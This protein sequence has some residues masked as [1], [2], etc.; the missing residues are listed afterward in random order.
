MLSDYTI[1]II[2]VII[3]I[4]WLYESHIVN[5][6]KIFLVISV[7]MLVVLAFFVNPIRAYTE[8]NSYID[9]YRYYHDI[10]IF[11]LYGWNAPF[12]NYARPDNMLWTPYDTIPIVKLIVY[13]IA[14]IGIPGLLPALACLVEYGLTGNLL[15][16]INKDFGISPAVCALAFVIFCVI[17][18]F[19]NTIAN[20]RMP[21]GNVIFFYFLYIDLEEGKG[22]RFSLIGYIICCMLHS[23]FIVFLILRLL[24]SLA[25]KGSFKAIMIVSASLGLFL[26]FSGAIGTA[27]SNVLIS[28]ILSKISFYTQDEIAKQADNLYYLLA[29]L[30]LFWLLASLKVAKR[31]IPKEK[32]PQRMYM[33]SMIT[34]FFMIGGYWNFHLFTRMGNFLVMFI[35]YWCTLIL[36]TYKNKG[37]YRSVLRSG[38]ISG[39]QLIAYSISMYTF[40]YFC[41]SHVYNMFWF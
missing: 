29:V 18:N 16:K 32:F 14:K 7:S 31:R 33:M 20:I 23:I 27:S 36:D 41:F 8:H 38:T 1:A 5:S 3:L 6:L 13:G 25:N 39:Y 40:L 37:D 2:L 19:G 34:I 10:Y 28:S 35:I 30:R 12:V 11:R 26:N 4:F 17:N 9:L 24:L 22:L 15:L 21:V